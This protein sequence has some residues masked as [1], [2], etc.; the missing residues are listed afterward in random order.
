[1]GALKPSKKVLTK[2]VKILRKAVLGTF[3][4]VG[5]G[6][7]SS[8]F[9][10]NSFEIRFQ[11]TKVHTSGFFANAWRNGKHVQTNDFLII[12]KRHRFCLF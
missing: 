8:H 5:L 1:M 12:K 2:D 4:R 11:K 9:F 3:L 6:V 7:L 10:V